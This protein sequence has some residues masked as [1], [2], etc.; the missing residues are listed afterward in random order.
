MDV[1]FKSDSGSVV[2]NISLL[3]GGS[4][5]VVKVAVNCSL[6]GMVGVA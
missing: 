4:V 1:D 5:A 6:L 2:S 3:F